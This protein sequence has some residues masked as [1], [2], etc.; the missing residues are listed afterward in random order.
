MRRTARLVLVLG[1]AGTVF[2]G[3][4]PARFSQTARLQIVTLRPLTVGGTG[5][6]PR[7][8][9]R[10]TAN[11]GSDSQTV[12]VVATR[13]GTFRVILAQVAPTRCDLIRVVAVRRVGAIVALKRL[14][15]PACLPVR[16]S[17]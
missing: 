10:V 12:R 4:S 6:H 15:S 9:T 5:F 8:R 16:S 2:A 1:L 17:G 14:P 7:E 11:T 13:L 3:P